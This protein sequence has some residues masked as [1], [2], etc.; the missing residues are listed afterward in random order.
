MFSIMRGRLNGG[1]PGIQGGFIMIP[2]K[3]FTGK[4]SVFFYAGALYRKVIKNSF[5]NKIFLVYLAITFV[6]CIILFSR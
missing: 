5:F 2:E 6:S 1:R 4:K 3:Y